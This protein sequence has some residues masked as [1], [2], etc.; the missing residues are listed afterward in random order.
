MVLKT[1]IITIEL[2]RVKKAEVKVSV[3]KRNL[4][5]KGSKEDLDLFRC[6]YMNA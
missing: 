3:S 4:S 2:S 6:C 1:I 5:V